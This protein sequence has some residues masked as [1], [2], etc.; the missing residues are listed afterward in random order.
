[1]T[2]PEHPH[3][4]T[5][6]QFFEAAG[7]YDLAVGRGSRAWNVLHYVLGEL[8][9]VV[10]GGN[11]DLILAAWRSIENDRALREMLW[12]AIE[13]VSPERWK[14]TPKA[15]DD[16]I[17]VLKRANKLSDVRNDAIHALVS[18]YGGAGTA[19]M[20]GALPARG[21]REK[22]LLAKT[23]AGRKL[24]DK[25]AKCEQDADALRFFV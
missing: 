23:A 24:L 16:L 11:R 6:A 9:A 18:L 13:A 14:K 15:P 19:E 8:F 10:V 2:K 5:S 22:S 20:K 3:L 12:A 25:F 4:L 1:M 7:A 21:R 17:S